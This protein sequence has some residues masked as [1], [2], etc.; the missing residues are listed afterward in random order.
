[1]R[2]ITARETWFEQQWHTDL[3][4]CLGAA[5]YALDPPQSPL[6]QAWGGPSEQ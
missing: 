6:F 4:G 2:Q 3:R 1:M 5:E